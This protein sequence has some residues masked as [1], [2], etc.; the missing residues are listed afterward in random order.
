MKRGR[1]RMKVRIP[2]TVNELTPAERRNVE[3]F[4][5]EVA[6][7]QLNKD[8]R[9]VLDLYVKMVCLTLHNTFGF[10]EKRLDTFLAQHKALFIEQQRLVNAGTQLEVINER[11]GK[12]FRR[13][14]FPQYFFDKMLGPV[15]ISEREGEK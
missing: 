12:I 3:A 2:K 1:A 6:N 9:V 7:E 11:I 15:E 8:M 14:G 5:L 13:H 4:A 10:G